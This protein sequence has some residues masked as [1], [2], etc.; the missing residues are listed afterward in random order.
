VKWKVKVLKKPSKRLPKLRELISRARFDQ[1]LR[2]AI[3]LQ[4]LGKDLAC[5]AWLEF[6][7]EHNDRKNLTEGKLA[8]QGPEMVALCRMLFTKRPDSEFRRSRIGGALF[9]GG[10]NY[11]DWPLEPIEIVDGVPFSVVG[12][13]VIAGEAEPINIYLGYCMGN[14]DWNSYRFGAKSEVQKEEAL[15]KLLALPKW[16]QDLTAWEKDF[17]LAQ[18]R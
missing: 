15:K 11:D 10:T 7:K 13:Y 18:I 8:N 3:E 9:L 12:G 6:L 2:A 1:F 4:A 17:F 5:N 16:K 14:C